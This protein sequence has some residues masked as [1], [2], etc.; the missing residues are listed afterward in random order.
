[1]DLAPN[2]IRHFT[3]LAGSIAGAPEH[4]TDAIAHIAGAPQDTTQPPNAAMFDAEQ[5]GIPQDTAEPQ[6]EAM[7]ESTLKTIVLQHMQDSHQWYGTGKLA[8]DRI[9]ADQYY[10]GELRGDEQ[11][12]RS[13]VVSRDVAEA[14]DTV[15]PSLL[16]IFASGEE[17]VKMDA[18]LPGSEEAAKQATDYLNYLFLQKNNGFEVLYTWFKDALLKKN[19]IAKVWY[20][21]RISRKKDNY[22]GLSQPELAVLQADAGK[23]VLNVKQDMTSIE[24]MDPM[25]GMPQVQQVPIFSCTVI[26]T[27]PV[28]KICVGNVPPDEF[29]IQRR[30]INADTATFLG[31]RCKR[32][33]SDLIEVGFDPDLVASIPSGDTGE[34]TQERTERF[35]DE[36]TMA[37]DSSGEN[38]DPAMRSIWVNEVYLKVDF[39]GDGIAEWRKIILAGETGTSVMLC[40]EEVDDHPFASV[41]PTIMPHKFYGWSL[42]DQVVDIQDIK[43]ALLR[44]S[45]DSIYLANQPRLGVV[46]NQANLDDLLDSRVGG[47]VRLKNPNAIVPIPTVMAAPQAFEMTEYIDS[48]KEKRTGVTAYN[49]GLDADSLNKTAT[50]INIITNQAAQREELIARVFAETGVKRLFRRLFELTCLHENQPQM[51]QLR[52]KWV[53]IDPRSW[54][55]KMD[56]TV[57]VGI[58]LGN[59]NQQMQQAMALLNIDEKIVQMQGGV[60]G[61]IVTAE[62]IY[63]KLVKVIEATGWKTPEP[64]YTDPKN[65]PPPAPKPPTPDVMKDQT[66]LQIKQVDLQMKNID[67]EIKRLEAAILSHGLVTGAPPMPMNPQGM[68]LPGAM[69][70]PGMGAGTP[71]PMGPHA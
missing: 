57:S 67:L 5:P 68:P 34:L 37:W 4:V 24:V 3:D 17:V 25:S 30:A 66:M 53:N 21:T 44:G 2:D 55:D 32:T 36:D 29:I 22:E 1:M 19:G 71:P 18:K 11:E 52:G 46:E 62:N 69:P 23:Q 20:E 38:L 7:S 26:R 41:T 65:A 10:K 40:N 64:Y 48:V 35:A 49:Q 42:F 58:G 45:L 28:K 16:R 61:P 31:Q 8:S 51:I 14:V 47:I 12:G 60:Q 70:P 50:G 27:K 59:K 15:L 6:Q 56:V 13:Q 39:D 9:K 63:N 33:A 43:T 54:E